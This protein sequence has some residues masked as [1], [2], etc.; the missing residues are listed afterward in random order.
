[1]MPNPLPQGDPQ[2][3]LP[4]QALP[5]AN[6]LN[7]ETFG[8]VA[9][10]LFG[11]LIVYLFL[12]LSARQRVQ[13]TPKPPANPAVH[14]VPGT[15]QPD[16]SLRLQQSYAGWNREPKPAIPV[17]EPVTLSGRNG[18]IMQGV[19]LFLHSYRKASMTRRFPCPMHTGTIRPL[20]RQPH[21]HP[22]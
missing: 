9:L 8:L 15:P 2:P 3:L 11:A 1:M 7:K 6:R 10:G 19:T 18:E 4:R 21:P 17:A 13:E 12:T 16:I 5:R 14:E 20:S 22:S